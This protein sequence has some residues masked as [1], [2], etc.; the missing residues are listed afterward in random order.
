[1]LAHVGSDLVAVAR[2]VTWFGWTVPVPLEL[3]LVALSAIAALAV[4]VTQFGR[5]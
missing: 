5:D 2:G 4:A 1:V 3:A